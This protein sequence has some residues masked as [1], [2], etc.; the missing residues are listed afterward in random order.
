MNKT[1]LEFIKQHAPCYI[2]DKSVITERC[3]VL[4]SAMPEA[5]FL[6]SIKT[7]PFLPVIETVAAEGFGADA[8]SAGEVIKA[9]EAGISP[10]NIYYSSPGKTREDIEKVFGKCVIIADSLSELE[11]LSDYAASKGETC[12]AGIRINPLFTMGGESPSPSKFGIDEEILTP[13]SLDFPNIKITGI[14]IHLK[15]Q[16]LD[17][18][19]L[20]RYYENCY[21]LGRRING[22]PGVCIEF[23]NFGSGIGTVYDKACEKPLDCDRIALT[24]KKLTKQNEATL[25]GTLI[26]ET[27]RFLVCNAGTY[28][29]KI[30][31]KKVSRGRT[32]IIVENGLNGFLRPAVAQ[33]LKRNTGSYPE[34]GQEPLYTSPV[35]CSFSLPERSEDGEMEIVDIAGNLCTSLD[36]MAEGITLPVAET[37]DIVAVTNAGSYGLTLS[38]VMFSSHRPPKEF[39]L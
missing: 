10:E 18:D 21:D 27:G 36:V 19:T 7:N 1:T 23:I 35:Q 34:W 15:S 12:S 33:L 16:V 20:C 13:E 28:Y 39:L 24:V 11:M 26:F 38:P 17:A 31:D 2:Y 9:L 30:V 4:R 25:R 5:L 14:H 29:T 32:Y 37:G 3:R 22:L 6:Y 8:A